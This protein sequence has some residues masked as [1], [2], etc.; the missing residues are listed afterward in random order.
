MAFAPGVYPSDL[1]A[2]L[3]ELGHV[4]CPE[5]LSLRGDPCIEGAETERRRGTGTA[6]RRGSLREG[7][8]GASVVERSRVRLEAD[9]GG[10]KRIQE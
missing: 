6:G 2:D 1:L 7:Q 3:A 5:N 4:F 8:S 9:P 10:V